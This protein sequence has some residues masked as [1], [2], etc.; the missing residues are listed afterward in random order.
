MP[1]YGGA[2]VSYEGLIK[3]R[4]HDSLSAGWIYGKTS[5]YIPNA[6]AAKLFEANYQWVAKRYI[7]VVPD[8]QYIWDRTGTHATGTAVLGLQINLTF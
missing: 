2:G 3:K 5:S 4:K 7:T 6:S 8:F 1:V